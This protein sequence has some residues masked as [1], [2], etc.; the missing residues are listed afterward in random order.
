MRYSR[1]D[2]GF[3]RVA[4][5]DIE[6][7]H[8]K[9]EEGETVS[10]GIGVHDRGTPADGATYEMFHRNG[11]GEA[12]LIS[13]A[14]QHLNDFEADGLVSY[15]GRHFDLDFL[16]KRS[17]ILEESVGGVDLATPETHVD[18]FEDRKTE[19]ERLNNKWPKLEECIES[20]E[21]TP[22]TTIWGGSELTN[23]RFGEELG[24]TYLE[25]LGAGDEDRCAALVDV[26]EHYLVTDLEAN[27][28]I[29][30]GDIGETFEPA[31]L[32]STMT[33]SA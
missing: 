16:Y 15:K 30:Y 4:T 23:V 31:H 26:I 14:L 19:A 28:A 17:H 12:A 1:E 18:L 5:I 21:W 29:Y 6:T 24:P 9:P 20:Y 7:T 25:A 22:A 27:I 13:R 10:I 8:Y 11:D 32:G 2:T 33:F 3:E